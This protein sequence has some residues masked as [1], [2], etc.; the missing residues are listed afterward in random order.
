MPRRTAALALFA[1]LTI[2][3]TW[4]LVTAPA[5]LSRN[6]N[7]DTMLNEW[8]IAWVAHQLPRQPLHLFDA[9]IFYPNRDTLA[10]SE[11]LFVPALAGAPLFWLGASPVLVYNVLLL[12]GFV[13]TGWAGWYVMARWTGDWWAGALSGSI[14]AFNAHTFTRLPHLQALHGEFLPLALLALDDLLRVPRLRSALRLALW[15]TLQ[16]LTSFY[17][18][19]FSVIA[20]SA[21][22]LVR[23]TEWIGRNRRRVV[24]LLLLSAAVAVIVLL[25]FLLPYLRLGERRPL[26]EVR[27]FSAGWRD[28][29]TTPARIHY[30]VWSRR[31]FSGTGLFPGVI[32]LALTAIAI[33]TGIAFR[34]RR[35]RMA[36]AFGLAGLALSFGPT[37]PGYAVLY[38]VLPLLGGIRAAGRFGYL[39]IVATAMLSGFALAAAR[40]RWAAR[41]WLLGATIVVVALANL[42]GLVAPVG[43]VPAEPIPTIYD[44]LA[45]IDHAIVVE[46]PFPPPDSFARNAQYML[47]STRHWHPM[48]NGFSGLLTNSY[49]AQFA[50]LQNFPDDASIAALRRLHVTHIVVHTG[51]LE[52]SGGRA[53]VGAVLLSP[54][55]QLMAQEGDIAL[56]RLRTADG[57]S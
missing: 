40:R 44:R 9:N 11:H 36:L 1:V 21:G 6:D 25:P 24:P 34:D 50:D 27:L 26:D 38:K 48:L 18:L 47:A 46:I 7:A 52:A 14:L 10:Y 45:R 8:T 28:Y 20:L 19:V 12:A 31:W 16:S 57:S 39:V 54:D 4:P 35:A 32:G 51:L 17:T 41:P 3:H 30:S 13:L 42:D 22:A 29:L 53:A 56:Y 23:P 5:Q 15:F 55:L 37:F 33:M 49:E 2:V 43:F